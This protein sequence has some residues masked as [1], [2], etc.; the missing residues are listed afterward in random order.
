MR[1]MASTRKEWLAKKLPSDKLGMADIG[2]LYRVGSDGSSILNLVYFASPYH[3]PFELDGQLTREVQEY[4][5]DAKRFINPQIHISNIAFLWPRLLAYISDDSSN[6]LGDI[7]L[8]SMTITIYAGRRMHYDDQIN[9]YRIKLQDE[10]LNIQYS[11]SDSEDV[12]SSMNR[13]LVSLSLASYDRLASEF[14]Y[15]FDRGM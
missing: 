2:V 8:F 15:L 14:S 11:Q 10:W 5:E 7:R 3:P 9:G 4:V 1:A 6:H 12:L 13:Y